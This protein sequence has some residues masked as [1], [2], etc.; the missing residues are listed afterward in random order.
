MTSTKRRT[1]TSILGVLVAST[2]AFAGVANAE[3]QPP[4]VRYEVSGTSPVAEYLSYQTDTGQ[5]HEANVNLPWSTQFNA[6]QGQVFLLSAQGPGSITCRILVNG[7]VVNQATANGQ[8]ARTVCS[9]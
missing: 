8:P 3:P 6:W 5:Q 4:K 2:V 9:H 1:G 7:N